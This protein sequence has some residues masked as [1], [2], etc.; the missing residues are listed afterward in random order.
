M[1]SRSVDQV[2]SQGEIDQGYDND[3]GQKGIYFVCIELIELYKKIVPKNLI[4]KANSN[5]SNEVDRAKY[6]YTK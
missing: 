2:N 4:F 6:Y 1:L 5:K 3:K